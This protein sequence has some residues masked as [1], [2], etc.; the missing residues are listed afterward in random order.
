MAHAKAKLDAVYTSAAKL[1]A[2]RE[3]DGVVLAE[4][5]RALAEGQADVEAREALRQRT[6]ASLPLLQRWS[7]DSAR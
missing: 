2:A 5:E 3:A 6:H 1:A 7:R 4:R